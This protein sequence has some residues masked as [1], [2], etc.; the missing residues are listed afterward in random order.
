MLDDEVDEV[1]VVV[2]V[3]YDDV[4]DDD[5]VMVIDV[6][7][8]HIIDDEV[9]V[10]I[11]HIAVLLDEIDTNEYLYYVIQHLLDII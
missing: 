1:G 10:E 8:L 5:E 4:D 11:Q 7:M 2:L 3:D 6:L 9:L